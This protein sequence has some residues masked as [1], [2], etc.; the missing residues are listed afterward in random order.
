MAIDPP[1]ESK[2]K[3]TKTI[4]EKRAQN[5]LPTHSSQDEAAR[6]PTPSILSGANVKARKATNIFYRRSLR[7]CHYQR[8]RLW[9]L[10]DRKHLS[11]D[12]RAPRI[13][14]DHRIVVVAA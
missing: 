2:E 13:T 8:Q 7:T 12:P 4:S 6:Q 14:L 11:R 10:R 5:G 9:P 1:L 3:P